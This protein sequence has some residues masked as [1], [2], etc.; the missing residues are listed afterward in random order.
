LSIKWFGFQGTNI[1]SFFER[2]KFSGDFFGKNLEN[3]FF[4]F[5]KSAK[6][7]R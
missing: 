5:E 4:T 6:F 1:E 7:Q 2:E 3:N